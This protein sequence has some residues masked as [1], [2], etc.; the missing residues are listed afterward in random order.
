MLGL[1]TQESDEF[2]NFFT[3]V[4][5][6]ANKM[7]NVF[8]MDFGQC[9]DIDFEDIEIDRLFGWLIPENENKTFEKLFI[10]D[11]VSEKWD[12]YCTWVT[13]EIVDGK[14]KIRFD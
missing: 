1:R 7:G 8:F 6:E 14:L 9:D 4:Q 11:K 5:S 2:I 10:N 12:K 3:I 13:P